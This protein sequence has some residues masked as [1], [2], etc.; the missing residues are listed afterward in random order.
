MALPKAPTPGNMRLY[1]DAL[2]GWNVSRGAE[3]DRSLMEVRGG[4]DPLK[5]VAKLGEGVSEALDVTCA[6][7]E[8]I[9]THGGRGGRGRR[10]GLCRASWVWVRSDVQ[11]VQ[12]E[13][14]R[15]MP[16][17]ASNLISPTKLSSRPQSHHRS[18]CLYSE[19]NIP[20]P[21]VHK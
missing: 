3:T 18:P 20:G 11:D 6:I 12:I 8:E 17:A 4:G 9:E 10:G 7:V 15:K 21:S 5:G 19:L 2:A 16:Q 14:T 1:K 13:S